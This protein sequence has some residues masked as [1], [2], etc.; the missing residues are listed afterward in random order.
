MLIVTHMIVLTSTLYYVLYCCTVNL[1]LCHKTFQLLASPRDA[2]DRVHP[3][4]TFVC[5][6]DYYTN[7]HVSTWDVMRHPDFS[8]WFSRQDCCQ[9]MGHGLS[10]PALYGLGIINDLHLVTLVF[11][12]NPNPYSPTHHWARA[13]DLT[14]NPCHFS[15]W[16]IF[17]S[18]LH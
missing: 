12:H 9:C 8:S 5:R 14:I 11:S 13:S 17:C 16:S 7:S 1:A 6:S 10:L 18:V 3:N 2:Q 4:I 15:F